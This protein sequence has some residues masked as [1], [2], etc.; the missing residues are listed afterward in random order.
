MSWHLV[1]EIKGRTHVA[2]R[3]LHCLLDA[4]RDLG[5]GERSLGEHRYIELR[6]GL[7]RVQWEHTHHQRCHPPCV[8]GHDDG[9]PLQAILLEDVDGDNVVLDLLLV[10]L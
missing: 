9:R 2:P 1:D 4:L 6:L 10:L 3:E 7:H 5:V 8:V